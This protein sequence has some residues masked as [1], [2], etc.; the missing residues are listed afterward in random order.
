MTL[1]CAS[2]C[3]LASSLSG[4]DGQLESSHNPRVVV[5]G[6]LHADINA[7]REAFQLAGAVDES[8][9]WV[10]G[11]MVIVQ[12][13][14][15]IGRS[16]DD[17]EVLDF[18]LSVRDEAKAAGGQVHILIGNHEVFGAELELEWVSDNAYAAF[19]DIPGLQ[20]NDPRLADVSAAKRARSAA[21][22]AGGHYASKMS[23][24]PAVLR[25]GNTIFTHGGVTPYWAEYGI[26]KINAEVGLWFAGEIDQPASALG[27]DPRH[28]DDNVMMSRH[29]SEEVGPDECAMLDESL[30]TLG[31]K[32]MVVAHTVQESITSYCDGKVWAVDVGMSR[33]YGGRPEVLEIMNDDVVTVIR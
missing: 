17:R 5:I 16:H 31:A 13:G 19:E 21:L 2:L 30:K 12:T 24:F 33:F 10:G 18:V 22:M 23:D 27:R 20:L 3:L 15:I 14:D 1:A 26:D 28:F 8:D 9:S 32:R 29:F 7:A 11:N 4:C 25:L 6:D